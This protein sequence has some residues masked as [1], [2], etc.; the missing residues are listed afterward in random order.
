MDKKIDYDP[1]V[2]YGVLGVLAVVL[3]YFIFFQGQ[4]TTWTMNIPAGTPLVLVASATDQSNFEHI[5]LG[6]EIKVSTTSLTY[7][8]RLDDVRLQ[9]TEPVKVLNGRFTVLTPG[10]ILGAR[11]DLDKQGNIVVSQ[12]FLH[13]NRGLIPV[14][15][16]L[17]TD[18]KPFVQIMDFWETV[19]SKF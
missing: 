3:I 17:E 19:G 14:K 12:V 7:G 9:V 18:G 4:G 1:K 6:E 8:P 11:F 16:K 13:T 15:V 10:M 2:R 5:P